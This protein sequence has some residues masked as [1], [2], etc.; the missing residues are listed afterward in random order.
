VQGLLAKG[1]T[2]VTIPDI[3]RPYGLGG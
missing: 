2:F 1:Y 3:Q